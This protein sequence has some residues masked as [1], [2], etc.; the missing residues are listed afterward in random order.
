MKKMFSL[1][2]CG[3]LACGSAFVSVSC[4]T[5]SDSSIDLP[6]EKDPADTSVPA[7]EISITSAKN[8]IGAAEELSL[9]AN[10]NPSN[11]TDNVSWSIT[12]GSG[13]A[14]LSANSGKTVKLTG[15]NTEESNASVTVKAVAGN[16][17]ATKTITVKGKVPE[18]PLTTQVTFARNEYDK[19]SA[20]YK[21]IQALVTLRNEKNPLANVQEGETYILTMKG[22]STRAISPQIL[23]WDGNGSG[24]NITPWGVNQTFDTTFDITREFVIGTAPK[25]NNAVSFQL[26]MDVP[27]GASATADVEPVTFT[28]TAFSLV[29]KGSSGPVEENLP[30]NSLDMAKAMTIGW[31]LG[32]ALDAHLDSSKNKDSE[33]DW[34][35]PL[36]TKAMID[37]VAAK[38]FK[39]IRIPVSWHNHISNESTYAINKT[40]MARVK[41]VVDWAYKD[42]GMYVILNIHHDNRSVDEF[43]SSVGFCLSEDAAVQTRSKAFISSVWTQIATEFA[44]YNNRLVFEVLNEPRDIGGKVWESE[45]STNSSAVC[46]IITSYEKAGIDAIRAV[47]GNENRYLM[48]PGYAASADVGILNYFTLPSDSATD[49]LMVS[50][51]A[52]SPY[53]FAM[54]NGTEDHVQF[55]SS[56]ESSLTYLFSTL[57]SKYLDNGIGVVMGEAS[58]TDKQNTSERMKW[59]KSYFGKAKTAGIPIVLWDNMAFYDESRI[60][61]P[62]KKK[63]QFGEFHGW[64]N[65]NTLEWAN[66]SLVDEMINQTK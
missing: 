39:T 24:T 59:V 38:G 35:L 19:S 2:L 33:D 52:Y 21:G 53:E 60:D 64:L 18:K 56:D 26:M 46:N 12:S 14:V 44:E 1:F 65:R 27:A 29:K 36:T 34:G 37:A 66:E 58:A 6:S 16:V 61:T 40:W 47:S 15:K 42:N 5:G 17:S 13:K 31:N 20:N 3:L 57:K 43:T 8:E 45:W 25:D 4:S 49:R 41:Q 10:L 22:T 55:T 7:T 11:S 9:T 63:E 28:L 51:H 32:N 50:T 30:E 23:L 62:E 48:V 54:Y